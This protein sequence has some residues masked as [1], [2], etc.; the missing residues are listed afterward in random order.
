M[1][2]YK[3]S[4]FNLFSPSRIF[5][6]VDHHE[7]DIRHV[8]FACILNADPPS[9]VWGSFPASRHTRRGAFS[10]VDGHVELHKWRDPRTVQPSIRRPR[11]DGE[12][13]RG[14]NPDI[15]W[16]KDHATGLKPR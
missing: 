12:F 3:P 16:V 4:D 9:D 10:F 14:N 7:D 5:C 2:F 8:A 1:Y 15:A 6:F 11:G 13:G